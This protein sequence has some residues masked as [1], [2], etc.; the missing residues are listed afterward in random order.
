M[1]YNKKSVE[2]IDVKG[3]RVLCRCDFNVPTKEGKITSDKRIVAAMP[4]IEYLVNHGARV[5]LC[6]HMGKPK[7]EW[8]PELSLQVVADRLSE[9]LGKPVVMAKDVVG[10]DAKAKALLPEGRRCDAAGERPLHE[11]RDEERS[12]AVQG[13]GLS[14]RHLRE[15]RIRHGAARSFLHGRRGGLS[16]RCLRLPRGEGSLHYG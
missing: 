4:T 7:G 6:S 3:K 10:E 5:I 9:L 8:K 16:A 15:R 12:R 2:D 1:N 11:G 14:G 13:A